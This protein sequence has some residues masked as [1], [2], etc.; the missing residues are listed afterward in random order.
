MEKA[1]VIQPASEI[2]ACVAG[3]EHE[4]T[5]RAAGADDAGD[6]TSLLRG[7]ALA[8]RADE[9]RGA[10]DGGGDTAHGEHGDEQH[11]AVGEWQQRVRE[12]PRAGCRRR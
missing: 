3:R 8:D 2:T 5:E 1:A 11:G 10:A 12:P 7:N 4:L 9:E 6:K